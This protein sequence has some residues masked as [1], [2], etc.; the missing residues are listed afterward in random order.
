M[1]YKYDFNRKI[2]FEPAVRYKIGT[3]RRKHMMVTLRGLTMGGQYKVKAIVTVGTN[4]NSLNDNIQKTLDIVENQ[5]TIFDKE[6]VLM[7]FNNH[8]INSWFSLPPETADNFELALEIGALTD[9][10]LDITVGPLI[11]LWGFGVDQKNRTVPS[12]E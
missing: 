1:K 10:A 9:G 2:R 12:E 11:E 4:L 7:E 3:S 6:S 8:P 5:M